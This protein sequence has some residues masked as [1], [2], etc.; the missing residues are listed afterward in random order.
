MILDILRAALTG[1]WVFLEIFNRRGMTNPDDRAKFRL[2]FWLLPVC[3]LLPSLA[4]VVVPGKWVGLLFWMTFATLV[5]VEVFR[6]IR[7]AIGFT[8]TRSRSTP[9]PALDSTLETTRALQVRSYEIAGAPRSMHGM[10]VAFLSDLHCDGRP[11]CEWYDKLWDTL[12]GIGPD[13]LLLGG[14]YLSRE[15]SLPILDRCLKGLRSL[16]IPLGSW[17]VLGNHDMEAPDAV[18][19][20]LRQAGC[21]LLE[22]DWV[23]LDRGQGRVVILHGTNAP[24][25]TANPSAAIPAGGADISVSHTPDNAPLLARAGAR[26]ILSGH[27]HGGQIGLPILGALLSPSKFGRKWTYGCHTLQQSRLVVSS[28]VGVVGL[29]LRLLVPPE[30]VLLRFWSE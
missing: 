13:L 24:W 15:D 10:T 19:R 1:L 30:V 26:Y 29:P 14:D 11:S 4:I 6:L 27:I 25:S 22:D 23:P 17:A 16:H 5:S 3:V 2:A 18:R 20:L 9:I 7:K 8:S 12:R 28:G 21:G